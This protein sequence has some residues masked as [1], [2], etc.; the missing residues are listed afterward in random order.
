MSDLADAALAAEDLFAGDDARA[1]KSEKAVDA[2]RGRFGA[3][4]VVSA[5]ALKREAPDRA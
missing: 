4:A 3:K 1:L 2:L 5:R